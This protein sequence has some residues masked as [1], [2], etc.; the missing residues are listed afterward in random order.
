MQVDPAAKNVC[1]DYVRLKPDL[2]PSE[3]MVANLSRDGEVCKE[4]CGSTD[5]ADPPFPPSCQVYTCMRVC[6]CG[7][8]CVCEAPVG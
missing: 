8:V 6:E 1:E 7:C 5:D 4:L 3:V 2:N